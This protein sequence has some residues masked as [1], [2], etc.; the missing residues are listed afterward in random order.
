MSKTRFFRRIVPNNAFAYYRLERIA[1][2]S[3]VPSEPSYV[4]I[5]QNRVRLGRSR[6]PPTDLA[7]SLPLYILETEIRSMFEEVD[8][9]DMVT[10]VTLPTTTGTTKEDIEKPKRITRKE[11]LKEESDE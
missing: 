11:A 1:N 10:V 6:V 9:S 4:L 3:G 8:E 7:G 5:P 2:K